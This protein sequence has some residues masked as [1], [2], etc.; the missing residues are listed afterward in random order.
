MKLQGNDFFETM[1][2]DWEMPVG[3]VLPYWLTVSASL[4]I[5]VFLYAW[6]TDE[7]YNA[8]N[9]GMVVQVCEGREIWIVESKANSSR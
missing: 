4:W 3:R 1:V 7:G 9:D 2:L 8:Y 5:M 6:I